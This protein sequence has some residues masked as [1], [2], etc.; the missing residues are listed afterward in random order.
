MRHTLIAYRRWSYTLK[1]S[2]TR[3]NVPEPRCLMV[4]YVLFTIVVEPACTGDAVCTH[5]QGEVTTLLQETAGQREES[6]PGQSVVMNFGRQQTWH[7]V[8]KNRHML[9]AS[10]PT[11]DWSQLL[12]EDR[13]ELQ[14]QVGLRVAACPVPTQAPSH[15]SLPCRW[16]GGQSW[17]C[18]GP[19]TSSCTTQGST[20][21]TI[22]LSN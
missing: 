9:A 6:I 16:S 7:R 22:L 3:P 14:Q 15:C 13:N 11:I 4:M 2:I 17:W 10:M 8:P 18:L 1:H 19:P 21:G 20:A 5:T 12:T